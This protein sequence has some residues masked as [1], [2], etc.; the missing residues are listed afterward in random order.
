MPNDQNASHPQGS[1]HAQATGDRTTGR[2]VAAKAGSQGP[3]K[4][5]LMEPQNPEHDYSDLDQPQNKYPMR[6]AGLL[7]AGIAI[8][9]VASAIIVSIFV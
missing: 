2:G 6:W 3:A 7:G 9:I 1:A 5:V 8:V 4:K